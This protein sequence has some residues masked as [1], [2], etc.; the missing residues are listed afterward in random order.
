[1]ADN[2]VQVAGTVGR[3]PEVKSGPKG[4][5]VTFSV[6]AN[7]A[8]GDNGSRWYSVAVNDPLVQEFVKKNFHKGTAVVVEGYVNPKEYNGSTYYNMSGFRVG[9]VEWFVKGR[10]T[11]SESE[12]EDL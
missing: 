5:F 12:E 10:A 2:L 11:K 7:I 9:F 3:T 4:E 1:M 8:Y 6:A